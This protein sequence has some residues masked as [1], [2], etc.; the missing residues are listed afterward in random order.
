MLNAERSVETMLDDAAIGT[1]KQQISGEVLTPSAPSYESARRVWN[2]MIDCKP[3]VIVRP[4]NAADV[5]PVVAFA[6]EQK[7]PLAIRGGAHS[8]AGLGTCDAG[9]VIDFSSMKAITVDP[10]KRIARAEPGAKWVEFDKATQAHGLA[11]TGGTV[12][13]TGIAGL[14]LGGGF[15]WLEGAFGMTVDNLLAADV[16]LA[17]GKQVRASASENSDLFWALRG[18]GGNFGVVT[19]F[20]YKLH[21]LGPTIAGGMVVHPFP[22]ARD[23]FRFY[24]SLLQTAPDPLTAAAAILTG[25]DG[26]KACAIACAYAGPVEEGLRAVAPIK[27]FGSPVMDAIGPI[28]YIGQQG[29]LVQAMP[30][31]VY[32]YCKAEFLET[33]TDEFIVTWVDA[34]SRVVSPMSSLLLF[35]IHG[36]AARQPVDATAFSMRGGI[37]LGIY[38]LWQ[39]GEADAPN[40][41][42]VRDTWKRI[43]PFASGGL[44]V[45]EIGGDDGQDRVRQA[46][47]P[48][49]SRLAAIKAKYDPENLF[50]LNANIQ[51]AAV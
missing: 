51:P 22:A 20:E 7:L 11:T 9:V 23:V 40:V 33:P 46:Y 14:T 27:A 28:P 15:G 5:P 34:Y 47:G 38:A 6:R 10:E 25:P 29:L 13:D 44:Y 26:H 39:P 31:G 48:N 45:N 37:H 30:P 43:Q 41:Q 24:R 3:A 4:R 16:V 19:A 2:A 1:L 12:G 35:P 21:P 17:S 42:W 8:V 18:G 36:V 49:F 32:Y 50:R